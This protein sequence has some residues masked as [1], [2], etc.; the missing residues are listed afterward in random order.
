MQKLVAHFFTE[1]NNRIGLRLSVYFIAICL[2]FSVVSM[3]LLMASQYHY[4]EQQISDNADRAISTVED[5]LAKHLWDIDNAA[6]DSTLNG[7]LE[8]VA[9][10]GI[11]LSSDT[12][13]RYTRGNVQ[14]SADLVK[15]IT[16]DDRRVGEL[17]VYYQTHSLSDYL[18]PRFLELVLFPAVIILLMG[19]AFYIIVNHSIIRHIAHIS[20]ARKTHHIEE[21]YHHQPLSLSR[22]PHDDELTDLVDVLNAGRLKASELLEAQQVYQEQMEYQANYDLLTGLPNRRHLYSHLEQQIQRSRKTDVCLAVMFIDLDGFKQINDS[23]GHAIGDHVLKVCADRLKAFSD[24]IGGFIARLGGDEFILCSHFE[25]RPLLHKN[26]IAAI[27]VF[28]ERIESQ[29]LQV[30]LSCSIGITLFPDHP[31]QEMIDLIR[32]A[33]SALYKAKDNGKNTYVIF[34]NTMQQQLS[35]EKKIKRRLGTLNPEQ[36]LVIHYQPLMDIQRNKIVGFEALLRWHD[37]ELGS[38]PPDVFIGLAEKSGKIFDIDTWAFKTAVQ[39]VKQWRDRYDEDFIL[40]VNFSANNFYH[41][42]FVDWIQQESMFA[43][44]LNWV[45]LDVTEGLIDRTEVVVTNSINQ[46]KLKGVKFSI[47]DFGAGFSSLA[48]IKKFSGVLSK[49]K[50]DRVLIDDM[51]SERFDSALIQS[52]MILAESLDLEVLAEGVEN[53]QQLE[54]LRR[55]GCRYA[56]GFYFQ[57]PLCPADIEPLLDHSRQRIVR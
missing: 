52:I 43:T 16:H 45:E 17:S 56:Q 42:N 40:S 7:L 2:L 49:I 50:V 23:M 37:E 8:A 21:G 22:K 34:D 27:S 51:V 38:I 44:P 26:A 5:Q 20:R 11:S 6:I 12:D 30:G 33:D 39:Q 41:A 24:S 1:H 25:S 48:N 35:V 57:A 18:A 36:D 53:R 19:A 3:I 55:L 46:L 15:N 10:R 28:D 13:Q 54:Q 47:D 9:I 14:G 29:G 31:I 32:H 4:S